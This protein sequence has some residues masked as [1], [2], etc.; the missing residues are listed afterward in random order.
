MSSMPP[1]QF[2]GPPPGSTPVGLSNMVRSNVGGST[3]SGGG[4][5]IAKQFFAVEQALDNLASVLPEHSEQIDEIKAQLRE[6]LAKAISGGASFEKD[7]QSAGLNS[8]APD[9]F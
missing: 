3:P 5:G 7:A 6:I 1:S 9:L 8:S 2:S 4:G